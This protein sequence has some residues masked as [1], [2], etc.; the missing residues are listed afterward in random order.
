M[1]TFDHLIEENYESSDTDEDFL[2]ETLSDRI[3][4]LREQRLRGI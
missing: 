4:T 2:E 1:S 3:I